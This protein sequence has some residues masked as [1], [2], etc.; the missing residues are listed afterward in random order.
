VLKREHNTAMQKT[1]LFAEKD[2]ITM[3]T[4]DECKK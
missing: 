3:H 4:W 2:L 1:D